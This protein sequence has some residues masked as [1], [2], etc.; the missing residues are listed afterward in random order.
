MV[1]ELSELNI[2]IYITIQTDSLI[3]PNWLQTSGALW[4]DKHFYDLEID[5][6]TMLKSNVAN[7]S[8]SDKGRSH[9]KI[10]TSSFFSQIQKQQTQ[11]K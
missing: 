4:W 1:E 2:W 8:D 7:D 5:L 9:L 6:E 3:K 10:N 11:Y